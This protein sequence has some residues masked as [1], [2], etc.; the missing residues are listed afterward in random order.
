M[1]TLNVKLIDETTLELAQDGAKGDRIDL[2]KLQEDNIDMSLISSVFSKRF[3]KE[4]NSAIEQDRERISKEKE[5]EMKIALAD[6]EKELKD[7]YIE[8]KR[9][10]EKQVTKLT[11]EQESA[12]KTK[13]KELEIALA[14]QEKELKEKYLN[15]NKEL[16]KQVEKLTAEKQSLS[17]EKEIEINLA[18]REK[19][20]EFTNKE[21]FYKNQIDFITQDRD[22]W[23]DLRH[24]VNIKAF[25]TILENGCDDLWAE[26]QDFIPNATYIPDTA[27]GEKGDRIYREVD[28][29][30]NTVLSILFEMKWE[31]DD[32]DEKNKKKNKDHFAKLDRNR[33]QR[34]CE[35]AVL[36]SLLEPDNKTYD[37]PV[38]VHEYEKMFVIR[39]QHFKYI[40]ANLQL[41]KSELAY[42]NMQL[43][44]SKKQDIHLT[45]FVQDWNDFLEDWGNNVNLASK[46]FATFRKKLEDEIIDKQ[47]QLDTLNLIG[48]NLDLSLR[49]GS[50]FDLRQ[51]AKNVPALL[52]QFTDELKEN[53]KG[54]KSR[55]TS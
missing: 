8:Q 40:I 24:S 3:E 6:Q 30:D 49:K 46:H 20:L 16:G 33:K 48:K 47:N 1:K 43:A 2:K 23:K 15:E 54:T 51:K 27:S 13:E 42:T 18:K 11:A 45:T 5:M 44:E 21:T 53:T 14:N 29:D 4:K 41:L 36:V 26:I 55:K 52:M 25:G 7:K 35:F 19:E 10:L 9:E 50:K 38:I 28:K 34:D 37:A 32:T 39:P 12:N 22:K 31:R 17:K